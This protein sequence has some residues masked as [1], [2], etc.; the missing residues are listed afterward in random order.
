MLALASI[1]GGLVFRIRG[2]GLINLKSTTLSR[3]GWCITTAILVMFVYEDWFLALRTVPELFLGLAI[4]GWGSYMDL[5]RMPLPDNESIKKI[6][7]WLGRNLKDGSE[8]Y[9]TLGLAFRGWLVPLFAGIDIA[10]TQGNYLWLFTGAAMPFFYH[11]GWA[12]FKK[13]PTEAAEYMYGTHLW[14]MQ[15]FG[16]I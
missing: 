13:K 14:L 2:G 7:A 16:R 15:L 1:L 10:I 12:A 4:C 9:D 11:L 6:V 3:L 5:G 8:A